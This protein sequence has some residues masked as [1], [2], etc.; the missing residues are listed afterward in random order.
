MEAKDD[1]VAEMEKHSKWI[2]KANEKSVLISISKETP[3][4]PEDKSISCSVRD[5]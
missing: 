4:V 5:R 1:Y 2:Y 3:G